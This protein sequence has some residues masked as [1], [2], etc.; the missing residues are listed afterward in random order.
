M[1]ISAGVAPGPAI[2]RAGFE[3]M[4][5]RS[6]NTM[7]TSIHRIPAMATSRRAAKP[8]ISYLLA[9]AAKLTIQMY[10]GTW[11]NP[12][13]AALATALSWPS[14]TGM[15]NASWLARAP[16]AAYHFCCRAGVAAR[17]PALISLSRVLSLDWKRFSPPPVAQTG[18]AQV[19]GCAASGLKVL[20]VAFGAAPGLEA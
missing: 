5:V 19:S 14:S 10:A 11:E 12:V 4:T 3:G 8:S 13:I 17:A 7:V 20:I 6:T 15:T 2:V 18:L 1:A 16:A 9:S